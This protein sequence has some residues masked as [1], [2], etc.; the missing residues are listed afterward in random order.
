MKDDGKLVT[1]LAHA[2]TSKI[3]I[4]KENSEV[5]QGLKEPKFC[6]LYPPTIT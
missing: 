3:R 1:R 5:Y 6:L 2:E 4:R